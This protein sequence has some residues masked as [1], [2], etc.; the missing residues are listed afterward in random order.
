MSH[1]EHGF[2]QALFASGDIGLGLVD[3]DLRYVMVN[4]TLAA[5][6][7]LSA[8]EHAGRSVREVL[9]AFADQIEAML[10][11]VID[12]REPLI[13]F[14]VQGL[15]TDPSADRHFLGTYSPL[16]DGDSVIGVGALLVE[17]TERVRS[18]R[19]LTEQARSV[20]DNVVQDLTVAQLAM[21][22][23]EKDETS[24]AI[25]RALVVAKRVASNVLID[26]FVKGG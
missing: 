15:P 20:Y 10:R 9:P 11:Q 4:D 22:Q 14:T 23:G 8:E 21:E 7:G 19:S 5:V 2:L 1:F 12:T 25:K 17:I 16:I 6:N 26:G 13:D 3:T 18:E 24:E